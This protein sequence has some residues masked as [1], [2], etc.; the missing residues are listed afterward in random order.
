MSSATAAA[1]ARPTVLPGAAQPCGQ[2][3][4]DRREL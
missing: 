2:E 1:S 3:H 4:G